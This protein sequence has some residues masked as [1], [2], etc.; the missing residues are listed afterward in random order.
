MF[1]NYVSKST[2]IPIMP[3]N[4]ALSKACL[5]SLI[6]FIIKALT[7]QGSSP[8]YLPK[9]LNSKSGLS[10]LHRLPLNVNEVSI[11]YLLWSSL[12]AN[13]ACD[14][15]LPGDMYSYVFIS[16]FICLQT[17][18]K[19]GCKRARH[20]FSLL[21]V[22]WGYSKGFLYATVCALIV[23]SSNPSQMFVMVVELWLRVEVLCLIVHHS[24]SWLR[25]S[26]GHGLLLKYMFS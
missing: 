16:V 1:N 24:G 12:V 21:Q 25:C 11:C 8:L 13:C 26:L 15:P 17:A 9:I 7:M 20:G 14:R 10:V 6:H 5:L 23:P 19:F 3:M 18:K 2:S 4:V 22:Y